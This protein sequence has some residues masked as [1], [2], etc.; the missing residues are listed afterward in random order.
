[1]KRAAG[2]AEPG[3]NCGRRG[4]AVAPPAG[5]GGGTRWVVLWRQ[6]SAAEPMAEGGGQAA[7]AVVRS[8]GVAGRQVAG[9]R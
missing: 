6:P 7:S 1:V 9:R 2:S 5:S 4:T 8:G 3:K